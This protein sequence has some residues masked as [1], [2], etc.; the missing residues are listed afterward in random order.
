[1]GSNKVTLTQQQVEELFLKQGLQVIEP[2]VNSKKRIKAKCLNCGLIVQPYYRQ[3]WAGQRGCKD[4]FANS[5]R[6]SLD[7]INQ[8]LGA[9]QLEIIDEYKNSYTPFKTR[10]LKCGYL[11]EL[12][13]SNL[14]KKAIFHCA[15]CEPSKSYLKRKRTLTDSELEAIRKKF[16]EFGFEMIGEFKSN[17]RSVEVKHLTCLTVSER[18]LRS[19]QNGKG[20]CKGCKKNRDISLEEALLILENAGFD[21][22]TQYVNSS[23]PWES[24]C[25]K[26][27]RILK[28]MI[29]T[30]KSKKSGCAFCNRVKV[31][32]SDAEMIM[33]AAGYTPLEPYKSS[34]VKWKC[35]H[36]ICGK[37]TFPR[38]NS[39]HNGQGGCT[40]CVDKFS[41]YDLSYFY[42]IQNSF[43]DSLKIGISNTDSK[44][45]R[46]EVHAKH[47]WILVERI[48]FENGFLAYDFEQTLLT[49]IRN[50]LKVPYHLSKN[51]MPQGGWTETM[52]AES[53]SL[54]TLLKL[55]RSNK[56]GN[57]IN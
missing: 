41:Y 27:G 43:L 56:S 40:N 48:D 25:K 2:Y 35:R 6:L 8:T 17:N 32:P 1:M 49:F 36:E 30:L 45:D 39:I 4:C 47:G 21:P 37:I 23:T 28:P 44:G 18:T 33:L 29:A 10:C 42:V 16:K 5:Q 46:V 50:N 24:K 22:I 15:G 38:F 19:I 52:S 3:I 26:C 54:P 13:I 53:I 12:K 11:T 7:D 55:V 34:K 14:R 57:M 9:F 20:F 51:E 31:D